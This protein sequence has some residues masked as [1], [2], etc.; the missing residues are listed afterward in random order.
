MRKL[1]FIVSLFLVAATS[2][3]AK[4]WRG[5]VPLHS[6]RADVERAFGLPK[7][8]KNRLAV[9]SGRWV[10]FLKQEEVH[11]VFAVG[12]SKC[13]T[14]IPEG[15]IL[16][17]HVRPT[18]QRLVSSLDIDEKKFRNLDRTLR[19]PQDLEEVA[20]INEEDGLL[21]QTLKEKVLEMIY[22]PS[23]SDLRLCPDLSGRHLDSL[24]VPIVC[25]L[26][27]DTFG[28]IRFEDEKARL[29]NFAIQIMNQKDAHGFII[30][31]AGRKATV[32]EAQ[33]RANRA[34]NYMVKVRGIESGRL[35]AVDGGYRDELEI[36]LYVGPA[37]AE[38]PGLD[39]SLD[40]GQVEIVSTKK[41]RSPK[42]N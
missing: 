3:A 16:R 31:Y 33:R 30:V 12:E 1:V 41:R 36:K 10:Y 38:P 6:T 18:I 29:D 13:A 28:D 27:F 35:Y 22:V 21:I 32:N 20:L 9:N 14:P 17:I 26:A 23:A 24:L 37:G 15:T 4:D 42:R 39:P 34:K 5:F 7:A 25:G 2:A 40:P 11:F 8:T 19:Q